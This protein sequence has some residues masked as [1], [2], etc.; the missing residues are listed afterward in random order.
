VKKESRVDRRELTLYIAAALLG[1]AG[2][3]LLKWLGTA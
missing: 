2:E 1:I 3:L